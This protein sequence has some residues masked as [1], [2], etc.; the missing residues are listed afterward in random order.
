[1]KEYS[2][3]KMVSFAGLVA[4]FIMAYAFDRW[5][6]FLRVEASRTFALAPYLWL[7][8]AANLLL[9]ITLLLLTWYVIFRADKSTL[10]SSV[11]V[12]V[13]LAFTFAST[14]NMSLA[15]PLP[16]LGLVEFSTP[17]SHVL[18][19]SAFVAVIGIAG[20]VLPRRLNT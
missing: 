16:S 19:V 5:V 10:V 13:G 9:A 1:M 7:A 14:I 11:F 12:L 20:F 4:T 2:M 3:S 18:Y 6:E 17:G 15:S 8:G